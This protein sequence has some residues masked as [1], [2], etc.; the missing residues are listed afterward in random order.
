MRISYIHECSSLHIILCAWWED[1]PVCFHIAHMAFLLDRLNWILV[2]S[3]RGKHSC[4]NAA[5]L[6]LHYL[7][8]DSDILLT[9]SWDKISLQIL[10]TCDNMYNYGTCPCE[11]LA[12]S[13]FPWGRSFF[14]EIS[15][16]Q[17]HHSAIQV[18]RSALEFVLHLLFHF[19]LPS[20]CLIDSLN[21]VCACEWKKAEAVPNRI[22]LWGKSW[23][24]HG[25]L[26]VC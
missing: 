13:L 25:T 21:Q 14:H 6:C 5:F 3:W 9:F 23:I 18:L 24:L 11:A 2:Y 17:I 10:Y 1:V 26:P 20:S 22:K 12:L 7:M 15:F 4:G 16:L 19:L 8:S